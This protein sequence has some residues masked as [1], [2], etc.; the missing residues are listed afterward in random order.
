MGY[1]LT[2]PQGSFITNTAV[3]PSGTQPSNTI[4]TNGLI[5]SGLHFP[6]AFTGTKISFTASDSESGPFHPLYNSASVLVEL[7]VSADK[8]F[9]LNPDDFRGFRYIRIKSNAT[10]AADRSIVYSLRG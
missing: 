2:I 10:E 7:T 4:N 8:V 1:N 9:A 5:L 3:I 6:S